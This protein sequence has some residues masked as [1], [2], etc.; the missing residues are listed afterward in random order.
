MGESGK[1]QSH[2]EPSRCSTPH[3]FALSGTPRHSQASL[4]ATPSSSWDK[5]PVGLI[6]LTEMHHLPH[7]HPA[8][9]K[10]RLTSMTQNCHQ[11]GLVSVHLSLER[12]SCKKLLTFERGEGVG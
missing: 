7:A 10:Q 3:A 9:I 6:S 11:E 2:T 12:E 4:Q 8:K 1:G 5:R